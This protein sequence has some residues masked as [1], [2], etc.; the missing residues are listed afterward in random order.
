[1]MDIQKIQE[2]SIGIDEHLR[3][4]ESFIGVLREVKNSLDVMRE[5]H[6]KSYLY[7][8]SKMK[9]DVADLSEQLKKHGLPQSSEYEKSLSEIRAIANSNEWP[10]AV[11]PEYICRS[12]EKAQD[13]ANNILDIVV[14]EHLRGKKFLDF[15]CGKGHTI[16]SAL[17]REASVAMGY[18]LNISQTNANFTNDFKVVRES[19]P[20]DVILIHDV[21]DHIMQID[22]IEA[23]KQVGSVLANGGR[24]YVKNHP[25]SSRHGGHLYMNTNLAFLHL[26]LDD[27]E[28]TRIYGIPSDHNIK[29][30]TPLETYRYW[31][32]QAGFVIKSELP[33]KTTVEPFFTTPSVINE[34]LRKHWNTDVI[35]NYMEIDFVEYIVE[36]KTRTQ[37]IF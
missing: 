5:S 7:E 8:L 31:F 21:L 11:N 14:G 4:L 32:E 36:S 35:Q 6:S 12:E 37:Q 22:P 15:G 9:K 2:I 24:V 34:R 23:L 10:L 20:Y 30:V 17:I 27:I 3:K 19:A 1:M 16:K 25:W 28:L 13:R 33:T 26:I 18:D 29:V